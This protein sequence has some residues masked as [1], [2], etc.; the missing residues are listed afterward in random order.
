MSSLGIS[1]GEYTHA[2][3]DVIVMKKLAL[4]VGLGTGFVVGS[5][6][7]RAP[8]ERL[9]GAV[10]NVMGQ[11]KVES[12]LQAAA[13]SAESVRDATLDAATGVF[14]DAGDAA[15][16]AIDGASKKISNRAQRVEST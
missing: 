16:D 14:H 11:P 6:A 5:W 3:G 2:T 13:E 15:T 7:G 8:F 9:E 10:R 4:F 1:K 12:T